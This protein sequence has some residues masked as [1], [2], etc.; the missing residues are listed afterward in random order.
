MYR[1]PKF[2]GSRCVYVTSS[3]SELWCSFKLRLID[4]K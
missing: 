3:S 2:D 1:G 4:L